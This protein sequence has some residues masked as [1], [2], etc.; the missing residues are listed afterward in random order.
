MKTEIVPAFFH[1]SVVSQTPITTGRKEVSFVYE[2]ARPVSALTD[3]PAFLRRQ[4]LCTSSVAFA[5]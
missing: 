1:I 3:M 2:S 5:V 4:R